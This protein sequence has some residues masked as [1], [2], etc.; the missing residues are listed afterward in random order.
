MIK[1]MW[2]TDKKKLNKT[3]SVYLVAY[4]S[5]THKSIIQ[6][7]CKIAG[8]LDTTYPSFSASEVKIL[9]F[10]VTS[11]PFLRYFFTSVY[12]SLSGLLETSKLK[13]LE[14]SMLSEKGRKGI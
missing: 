9:L 12:S 10:L 2:S 11:L 7:Y 5:R 6:F 13:F 4:K 3:Y 8:F 1:G 14:G